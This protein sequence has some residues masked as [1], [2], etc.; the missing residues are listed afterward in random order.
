[1]ITAAAAPAALPVLDRTGHHP[2]PATRAVI[3]GAHCPVA[4]VPR[5]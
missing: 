5:T 2:G 3:H 1:M 4:V